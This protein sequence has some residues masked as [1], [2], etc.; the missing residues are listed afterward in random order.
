MTYLTCTSSPSLL[1]KS[2]VKIIILFCLE[3]GT[4]KQPDSDGTNACAFLSLKIAELILIKNHGPNYTH[5]F[6]TI[7]PLIESLIFSFPIHINSI[8]DVDKCYDID[9]ANNIML[10]NKLIHSMDI[11][12]VYES[13][14]IY[15]DETRMPLNSIIQKLDGIG[16][17]TCSPYIFLVGND[18]DKP[19]IIDSHAF[20]K[21]LGGNN[22]GIIVT[23]PDTDNAVMWLL[24]RLYMSGI[25]SG[26]LNMR[27]V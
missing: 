26:C 24:Q 3:G 7:K 4:F 6:H 19:F 15:S 21:T 27:Q 14:Q 25:T 1:G 12:A 20:P 9:T 8:R 11:N 23:F 17:L 5:N 16:I 22:N 10:N 2:A 18:S 13:T